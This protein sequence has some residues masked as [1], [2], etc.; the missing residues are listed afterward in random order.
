MTNV[1]VP[2]LPAARPVFGPVSAVAIPTLY[3]LTGQQR[4][5]LVLAA[6]LAEDVFLDQHIALS[7]AELLGVRPWV[8][9]LAAALDAYRRSEHRMDFQVVTILGYSLV[10][11]DTTGMEQPRRRWPDQDRAPSVPELL[12]WALTQ[13][14]SSRDRIDPGVVS[15]ANQLL[16]AEAGIR[17]LEELSGEIASFHYSARQE[18]AHA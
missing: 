10:F 12:A 13:A 6:Y 7:L 9:G 4:V 14:A 8:T 11:R 16:C 5:R 17:S 18:L 3:N 1:L 2:P 15:T